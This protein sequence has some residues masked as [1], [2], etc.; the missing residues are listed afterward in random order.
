LD[1]DLFA[2]GLSLPHALK[3]SGRQ[4]KRVLRAVAARWLPASVATKPKKGF[5]VPVDTWV[6]TACKAQ[7]REE[8]LSTTSPLQGLLPS[9]IYQPTIEAF[10]TGRLLPSLTRQN[11]YQRAMMFLSMHTTLRP[12]AYCLTSIV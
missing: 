1:E 11:L 2:F 9:S 12:D 10:C 5:G 6:D 7:I 3:V 8:L 4:G